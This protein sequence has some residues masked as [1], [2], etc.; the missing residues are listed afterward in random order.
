MKGKTLD[1]AA[2]LTEKA[3]FQFLGSEGEELPKKAKG[4]LELMRRG[5]AR[6]QIA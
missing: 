3:F 1:E 4:L 6:Y 2:A 5:I